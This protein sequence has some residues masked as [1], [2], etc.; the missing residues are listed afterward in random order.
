VS[1]PVEA[2]PVSAPRYF[3]GQAHT[4]LTGAG[5]CALLVDSG[6]GARVTLGGRLHN[7]NPEE[8]DA[9]VER[10]SHGSRVATL[11]AE[12]AEAR[13]LPGGPSGL[14][15]A[16]RIVSARH[17]DVLP[18][19][20][21]ALAA[22]L[23][24]CGLTPPVVGLP[25]SARETHALAHDGRADILEFCAGVAPAPALLIAAVGHEGTDG[26]RFPATI[27]SALSVGTSDASGGLISYC[28]RDEAT[29]K[30][31]LLVPDLA[32]QC[33][34]DDGALARITGTSA[35]VAV[36]T[37]LALLWCEA[38]QRHGVATSAPILKSVLL[39]GS[40]PGRGWS[41]IAS[42][43]YLHDGCPPALF[44]DARPGS[45]I[46]LAL[47]GER[48][49]LA[50]TA[51]APRRVPRRWVE[52]VPYL[53]ATVADASGVRAETAGMGWCVIDERLP[54]GDYT[55]H[56]H[57]QSSSQRLPA[58]A[59]AAF[60]VSTASRVGTEG[61]R[62]RSRVIVGVSASQSAAACVLVDGRV[63]S[64]VQLERLTRRKRD[65]E[66][67]LRATEAIG[68][69]LD[70]C[71]ITPDEVDLF[72]FNA[73]PLLPG[74][75]GLSQPVADAAFGIFDPFGARVRFVSHH[76]AHAF[77][78]VAGSGFD[79][80]TALV[81]D[82]SG[83][84][85]VGSPDLVLTGPELQQYISRPAPCRPGVH[86]SSVYLFE[87]QRFR[88][89]DRETAESF[90]IRCGAT[91][92]GEVYAAVS[93]YLFHDWQEGGKLMGLAAYGRAEADRQSLLE[94]NA[95]GRLQF[96]RDWQ[97]EYRETRTVDPLSPRNRRL[98][99]IVQQDLER[100]L[101][102]RVRL[103]VEATDERRLA[104]SG[105]V[106]L[107]CLA[108]ARILAECGLRDLFVFPA[109]NDAGIA[110]GAAYAAAA[111]EAWPWTPQAWTHD[112]RG[113]SYG[114]DDCRIAVREYAPWLRS[115]PYDTHE[116]AA[117]LVA[118]QVVGWFEGASEFGPRALGHR[119]ILASPAAPWMRDHINRDI[120]HRE[121]FR[122]FAPVVPVER[123]RDF[124][125]T[126]IPSRFMLRVAAVRPDHRHLLA[127][128][129]HEDGTARVQSLDRALAP[130][131]HALLS[132]F[133]E[134]GRPP[135]LI[136]TSMNVRGQPIVETPLEAVE[137]LLST[138]LDAL[139]L[140]ERVLERVD[141]S[142]DPSARVRT[143]P[144]AR[145]VCRS[146]AGVTQ[147]M[148]ES[149]VSGDSYALPFGLFRAL[150]DADGDIPL[151]DLLQA[152]H[153]D[154]GERQAWLSLVEAFSAERL[155]LCR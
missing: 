103:A 57:A 128:V 49:R 117:R 133:G 21:H 13:D 92:P 24:E 64:A 72:A 105:G 108:N 144:G 70:A 33:H 76:L 65:G 30:P 41:R 14:A 123:L 110:V 98:A 58:L 7:L 149:T 97:N 8:D 148:L 146:V 91:S 17:Q 34:T 145:L 86:V 84:S 127:S 120:K 82:G 48:L 1:Q 116:M 79:R 75:L 143:A 136:N 55:L 94:R 124:F 142:V 47:R 147:P 126:D 135:V 118:G 15:P 90:N 77:A 3:L 141:K 88:L 132:A 45:P 155:L 95:A 109:S 59:V 102:E 100:W 99:A 139:V 101:I 112:F 26:V 38:L 50:V 138:D 137:L 74:W 32:W 130:R 89:V 67:F 43:D 93:Q 60:G 11:C 27:P 154:P 10:G 44:A 81:C 152:A 56:I 150:L 122:P 4:S 53:R 106:A 125:E 16:A 51:A 42:A 104:Y 20:W 2:A 119:S 73:Q 54:P 40:Q 39:A 107:N 83:G 69:C 80:A 96:R 134:A 87:G 153:A 46:R 68:Y 63:E 9:C 6:I 29:G 121:D 151:G 31:E 78:A 62:R 37:G 19:G 113:Y 115:R 140:G 131:L 22:R 12:G 35:A 23:R 66:G 5:A 28:G 114:E 52:P 111:A 85:T 129:C 36:T 18:H 25:W 61:P 71:G